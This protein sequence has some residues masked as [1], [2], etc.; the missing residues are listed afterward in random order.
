MR[1]EEAELLALLFFHGV[2]PFLLSGSL[3]DFAD[4]SVHSTHR[5]HFTGHMSFL[6][7]KC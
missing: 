6:S 4:V 5:S 3:P 1:K 7:R 2:V